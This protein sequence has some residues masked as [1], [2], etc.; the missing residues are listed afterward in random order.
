MIEMREACAEDCW[1]VYNIANDSLV[2]AVSFSS[3]PIPYED[4]KKWYAK[5]LGDP[6]CLFMLFFVDGKLA[7]QIRFAREDEDFAE[8]SISVAVAFRGRGLAPQCIELARE[9]LFRK[10]NVGCI[11]AL[12]KRDNDASNK[13]F[14]KT[15]FVLGEHRIFK[16]SECNVYV[17][18]R[19]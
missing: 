14:L 2:R 10:W 19:R 8:L 17:F 11:Q 9:A 7:A 16:G 18:K 15:G 3:D 6:D 5:R 1:E 4:H 12:V 13:L